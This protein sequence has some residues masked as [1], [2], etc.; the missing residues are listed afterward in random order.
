MFCFTKKEQIL[1]LD[2]AGLTA[3]SIK[4]TLRCFKKKKKDKAL[5]HK[6][7]HMQTANTV[8][9][10]MGWE[11]PMLLFSLSTAET[12][13][14][15]GSI[16]MLASQFVK[17][18]TVTSRPQYGTF[19]MGNEARKKNKSL[20]SSYPGCQFSHFSSLRSWSWDPSSQSALL[21]HSLANEC[22]YLNRREKEAME[23][24]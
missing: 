19:A 18:A 15:S 4:H 23:L 24:P 21:F 5:G 2:W 20:F 17:R 14:Y 1:C 11:I 10:W 12:P 8:G 7:M 6:W 22:N 9:I 13:K 16:Q 3:G